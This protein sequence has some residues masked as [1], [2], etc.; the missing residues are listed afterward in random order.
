MA[1]DT[2]VYKRIG[3]LGILPDELEKQLQR[4]EDEFSVSAEKLIEISSRF[5]QELRDGKLRP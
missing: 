2:H 4:L 1:F 3:S 5:E